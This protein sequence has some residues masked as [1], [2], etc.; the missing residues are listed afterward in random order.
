MVTGFAGNVC[1]NE[2]CKPKSILSNIKKLRATDLLKGW[3]EKGRLHGNFITDL[4]A[5]GCVSLN[6]DNGGTSG[7]KA[8][9]GTF[10]DITWF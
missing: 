1:A 8:F 3:F 10:N 5:N 4:F 2:D 7:G 9:N 6:L